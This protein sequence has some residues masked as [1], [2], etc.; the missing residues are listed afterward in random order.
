MSTKKRRIIVYALFI[1]VGSFFFLLWAIF[2]YRVHFRVANW[3]KYYWQKMPWKEI[4]ADPKSHVEPI[5]SF[6]VI[7]IIAIVAFFI[8]KK[9]KKR[10]KLEEQRQIEERHTRDQT[11]VELKCTD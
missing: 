8:S 4:W 6:F 2:R 10:K 5:I 3:S 9:I 7:G 11:K 1:S